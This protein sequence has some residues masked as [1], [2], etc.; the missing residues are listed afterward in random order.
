MDVFGSGRFIEFVQN[1][2]CLRKYCIFPNKQM[3]YLPKLIRLNS[4]DM[5]GL[6]LCRP[7]SYP[8]NDW[9]HASRTF[10]Y[11][12][13][14]RRLPI[15]F[16][17]FTIPPKTIYYIPSESE[18][19]IIIASTKPFAAHNT[20]GD[21]SQPPPPKS[22]VSTKYTLQFLRLV[23]IATRDICRVLY[24][25]QLSTRWHTIRRRWTW[26]S[27]RNP[28]CAS[29]TPTHIINFIDS[30]PSGWCYVWRRTQ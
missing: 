10:I 29:T 20:A 22:P 11:S 2:V 3:S 8:K 28:R 15:L 9:R 6:P 16:A 21:G 23:N 24:A 19:I 27:P 17:P 18:C 14:N 7:S 30:P 5:L 13:W 26:A 12:K 4:I 1:L 25:P